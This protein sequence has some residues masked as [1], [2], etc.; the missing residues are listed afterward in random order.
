MEFLP[1]SFKTQEMCIK[2]VK[3]DPWDL[4]QV[5]D[6]FKTQVMCDNAVFED[7]C[8]FQFVYDWFVTQKLVKISHG[9]K[10][11]CNDDEPAEWYNGYKNRKK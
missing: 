10:D 5:P 11:G 2:E 1:D 3:E 7:P 6:H 8:S 4:L 9:D